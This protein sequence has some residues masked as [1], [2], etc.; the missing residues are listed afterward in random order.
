MGFP[1]PDDATSRTDEAL[2][3]GINRGDP[4]ASEALYRRYSGWVYR[5]AWRF[6]GDRD[7]A[8][9]VLQET[10]AYLLAKSPRLSLTSRMTTFLY[11]AVKNLA[12]AARRKQRRYASNEEVILSLPAREPQPGS[13][14]AELAAALSALSEA[15]REVLLMRFVEDMEIRE[16]AAALRIPEGT[17]NSRLH[18]A[19]QALRTD[20]RTRR[21]FGV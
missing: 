15:Q 5:L 1:G 11:P 19:L 14:R 3:Q 2:I 4:S 21:Y 18:Y 17:V 20:E 12:I 9:D 10:F 6:T 16:I 8:L 13:S 7:L